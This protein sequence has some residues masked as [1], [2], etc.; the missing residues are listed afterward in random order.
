MLL[1]ALGRARESAR[2]AICTS[3]LK[4]IQLSALL[5][6]DHENNYVPN[7]YLRDG[8]VLWDMNYNRAAGMGLL[9]TGNYLAASNGQVLYCPSS[10]RGP[11]PN[12][13]EPGCSYSG[14]RTYFQKS[15]FWV[16]SHY[17]FNQCWLAGDPGP[18]YP[19]LFD[20]GSYVPGRVGRTAKPNYPLYADA[21][22]HYTSAVNT[23]N[24]AYKGLTVGYL[25]GHTKFLPT[26]QNMPDYSQRVF[27][28]NITE[29]W[30]MSCFW[31]W[32]KE[33]T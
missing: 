2:R 17:T 14:F 28:G 27:W 10:G 12:W 11:A 15:N 1:P 32:T 26:G 18:P 30:S 25:D 9:V 13:T 21:W 5:Y 7:W 3:N 29:G 20:G 22:F 4:N 23:V 31:A 19:N 8:A 24:H 6:L 16:R 33:G